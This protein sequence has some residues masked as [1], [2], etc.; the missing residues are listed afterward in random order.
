M[1]FTLTANM[2]QF[3]FAGTLLA[4]TQAFAPAFIAK[5]TRS[6]L[7][8][9]YGSYD[10]LEKNLLASGTPYVDFNLIVGKLSE[11]GG[12]PWTSVIGLGTPPQELKFMIDTGT[13][14]TWVTSSE[15]K[16]EACLVH[17]SFESASSTTFLPKS[18]PPKVVSFGPWGDMTVVN[19]SDV[20]W[21][22]LESE[23]QASLQEGVDIM[24]STNYTGEQ[25]KS[26]VCDGGM[27]VPSKHDPKATA[28]LEALTAQGFIKNSVASF[29]FDPSKGTGEC[30]MGSL[31]TDRF[32]KETM[33]TL[34]LI[35]PS[36]DELDYLWTVNLD[37][38]VI[39]N[40]AVANNIEFALDTGASWFKGGCGIIST[41]VNGIT[42]NGLLPT[43]LTYA[44]QLASYPEISLQISGR[45]YKL[46]PQQYFLKVEEEWVLGFHHLDG[47]DDQMLLVGS[48]FLE[49]IYS[50]FILGESRSDSQVILALPKG[51]H[52]DE[53][54]AASFD[55]EN[56]EWKNEFGSTLQIGPIAAEGTFSGYYKS[57]TGATGVYPVVGVA[58]PNPVGNSQAVSFSVTWRSLE[59]DYDPS[60]HFV[61][62]FTGL[63]QKDESGQQ[64]LKTVYLLQQNSSVDV[65]AYMATAVYPSTFTRT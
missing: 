60:W 56:S 47:L 62:G 64:T 40:K 52:E 36:I 43:R 4:G 49:T 35:K 2:M 19:G 61:S 7:T 3:I 33:Q 57:S 63:V 38:F 58:D 44:K 42:K 30:R 9:V 41:I 5:T 59:G 13:L 24:L 18:D 15:C 34:P 54:V 26:L 20:V 46:T 23:Q 21:L 55:I 25:F 48:T 10:E 45:T 11:N 14:N 16:T 8:K 6:P 32:D 27:A 17:N 51:Y 50:A 53:N 12:T 29:Y 31:N 37:A 28:L 39:G 1:V 22:D 65:E